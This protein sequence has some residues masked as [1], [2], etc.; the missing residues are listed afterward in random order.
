MGITIINRGN[1]TQKKLESYLKYSEIIKWGR[2]NPVKYIEFILGLEL[3]DYQKYVFTES[4][5]KQFSLWLMSRNAGKST[6]SSPFIMAKMMLFPNFQSY[7]LSLT[8]A[9]SQDTFIKMESIAKQ[10]IES[11]CGLTDIFLGEV[12]SAPNHD[13]FVHSPTGFRCKLYNNSQVTTVSGEEDN[14]R[15]KRSNLNLYDESGFISENYISTTKAFCTQDASFKLGGNV[16]T[17]TIPL[18]IP[19]QLLFC[20]SA[21]DTDSA[22]YKLYKE[23]AKLMFAG[24]KDHFVADLNCEV[25]IGATLRGK[26]L[27]IPLLSRSKVDDEIRN[28]SEKANREYFNKFDSDGGS[29][30][31]IKRSVIM[32]NSVIRKPLLVNDENIKRHIVLAYDPAHDYDNSAVSVGEYIYDEQVGWKLIIQNCVTLVDIGKKKKTPMRTPEQIDEIKQMLL[33]YNGNGFADYENIDCLMIDQGSGGGGA[34]IADYFM[35]DWKDKEGI[36]HRGL[37]DFD[38]CS[39]HVSKFP[40]AVNKLKLISPKKYR[41]EM[42]DDFIENLN[43]GLIEFTDTY[44][45]KGYLNLPTEG[46]EDIEE[47]D[48]ETGEKIKLKSIDYKTYKLSWEEE[49]ALKQIDIAKEEL[50]SN[51]R[52][53]ND[54]NY[55]YDLPPDKKSKIHDD[56]AYT[57]VMLAWHLKNLRREGITKKQSDTIDWEN[58]PM[59]VDSID[60]NHF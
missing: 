21:S 24:D 1:L 25:V 41:T 22:F 2:R 55:R 9:Q 30:Q 28:N 19:N 32:K 39:E 15:G 48:E 7:I 12:C 59:F 47:I 51:R 10:Q 54:A 14:I 38:V 40:N 31:P 46:K 29:Q 44:D 52:M 6:L 37:I 18:N 34:L 8:A 17:E 58:A 43:L 56:R 60:M 35:E 26:K 3:M 36:N 16:N 27:N 49:L 5:N 53:G 23:W 4:W 50:I 45:M 42:F 57:F 20:S 33:N 13:G 11:F